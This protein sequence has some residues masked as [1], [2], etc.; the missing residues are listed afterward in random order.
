[1]F[2]A[3][4]LALSSTVPC[5]SAVLGHS[6]VSIHVSGTLTRNLFSQTSNKYSSSVELESTIECHISSTSLRDIGKAVTELVLASG[7][8]SQSRHA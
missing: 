7:L 8:L 5:G 1:M 3:V 2:E 4:P 6:S